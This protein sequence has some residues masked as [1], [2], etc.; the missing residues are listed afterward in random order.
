MDLSLAVV[1]LCIA[2]CKKHLDSIEKRAKEIRYTPVK[3]SSSSSHSSSSS[4]LNEKFSPATLASPAFK[5][6]IT[7]SSPISSRENLS[8]DVTIIP[9]IP[10][11]KEIFNTQEV[12]ENNWKD[13]FD[14][15][16]D[17][18][19]ALT[20]WARSQLKANNYSFDKQATVKELFE[21]QLK[22]C[23]QVMLIRYHPDKGGEE[24][25]AQIL[26]IEFFKLQ[27]VSLWQFVL[28][29]NALYFEKLNIESL[30]NRLKLIDK[31]SDKLWETVA[32][33]GV[34]CKRLQQEYAKRRQEIEEDKQAVEKLAQTVE[35]QGQE[36]EEFK[37]EIKEYKQAFK[38]ELEHQTQEIRE[39]KQAFKQELEHQTQEI[40][41]YKQAFTGGTSI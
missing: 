40:R 39:Y 25:V 11:K 4:D 21:S 30:R 6:P 19:M 24:I 16:T 1:M 32:Q 5:N 9:P 31:G 2:Y 35:K 12:M 29:T 20:K 23:L 15:L 34:D 18:L 14:R 33:L 41:E 28:N 38:Q 13:D 10:F 3:R 27:G 17:F 36:I 22:Q 37:Q 8:A 26:E 7:T